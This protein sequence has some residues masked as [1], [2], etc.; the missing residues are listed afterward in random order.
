M[1]LNQLALAA[2]FVAVPFM[3]QAD[4]KA[5][6]DGALASVTGQ[7]GISLSGSFNGSIGAIVYTDKDTNGGSLRM[8]GITFT[9]FNISD[10]NPLMI[11]VVTTDI[12]GTDTQQLQISMPSM[13]GQVSI[14][15]IRVGGPTAASIGSLAIIDQNLAGTTLKIWGH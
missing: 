13:T 6:D 10:A 7:D 3:A 2:A 4:L 14:T 9:G 11:D 15:D 8:E 1:K 12:G 5:M